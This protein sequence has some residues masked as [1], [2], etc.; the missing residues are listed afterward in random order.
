MFSLKDKERYAGYTKDLKKRIGE[1]E[2]GLVESTKNRRPLQLIYYEACCNE[3]DARKREKYFKTKWG[4]LYLEKRLKDSYKN[5][6]KK[7]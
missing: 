4:F 1:H 3:E 5:I 6:F 7:L 2:Q